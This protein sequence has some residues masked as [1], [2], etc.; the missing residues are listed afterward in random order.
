MI[1]L[2]NGLHGTVAV[3]HVA[4]L[5]SEAYDAADSREASGVP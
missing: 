1:Q 3:K 4:E 2:R 5:V